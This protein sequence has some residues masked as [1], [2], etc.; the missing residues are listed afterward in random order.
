MRGLFSFGRST[1]NDVREFGFGEAMTNLRA[2]AS[3]ALGR[4]MAFHW[5]PEGI[6]NGAAL[7]L[8]VPHTRLST[9]VEWHDIGLGRG[10]ERTIDGFNIHLWRLQVNLC[11]EQGEMY[12]CDR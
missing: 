12:G 1:I 3:K 4:V 6:R 5:H 9:L 8:R 10:V 7:Y 2:D 11:N